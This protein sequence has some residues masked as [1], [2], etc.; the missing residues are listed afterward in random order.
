MRL[1]EYQS[2]IIFTKFGIP[3]PKGK[4]ATSV[5]QV[6]QIIGEL[7]LPLIIKA[8]V[9][10]SGRGKAGGICLAKDVNEVEEISSRLL[11][12]TIKGASVHK[13]LIEQVANFQG[14][15][16]LAIANDRITTCPVLTFSMPVAASNG[17]AVGSNTQNNIRVPI[18]PL[19]GL[20]NFQV[21]AAAFGLNLPRK[22]WTSFSVLAFGLWRIFIDTD[23]E[24][25]ELNPLVIDAEKGFLALDGKIFLDENALYRHSY[26][27]DMQEVNGEN[28]LVIEARKS[29]LDYVRMDGNIGCLTNGA[30]LGMAVMDTIDLF[31]GRPANFLDVRGSGSP[32]KVRMGLHILAKDNRIQSILINIFSINAGCDLFSMGILDSIKEDNLSVPIIVRMAG[33]NSDGAK[34]MLRGHAL[35]TIA[36][37]FEG[38]VQEAIVAAGGI[39]KGL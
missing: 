38:A 8:Q 23:A 19:I 20:V 15:F 33:I 13:I 1:H 34:N 6:K 29:G 9:R 10:I 17:E 21:R 11:G 16:Y 31:G 37:S 36:E 12:M 2:K 28:I 14:E 5:S 7:G 3:V 39:V 25:V 22:L 30:G 27:A 26:L 32:D 4:T 18:D 24:H 35:I